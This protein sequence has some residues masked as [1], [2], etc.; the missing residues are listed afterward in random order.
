MKQNRFIKLSLFKV[1]DKFKTF[2]SKVSSKVYGFIIDSLIRL[3]FLVVNPHKK[4]AEFLVSRELEY[5]KEAKERYG[6]QD[7]EKLK[8]YVQDKLAE[9]IKE[10]GLK[11]SR[12]IL[13][14]LLQKVFKSFVR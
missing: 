10:L 7:E 13:N 1:F 4:L 2:L 14:L 11:P 6:I 5:I 8:Q 3:Y 12:F 9:D